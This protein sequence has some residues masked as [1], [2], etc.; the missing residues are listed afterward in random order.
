M[1]LCIVMITF[2][3]SMQASCPEA[4][5]DRA[6]RVE[7]SLDA[8]SDIECFVIIRSALEQPVAVSFYYKKDRIGS[9]QDV[10][11]VPA[12]ESFSTI[13]GQKGTCFVIP[14]YRWCEKVATGGLKPAKVHL[15][16][17]L[18]GSSIVGVSVTKVGEAPPAKPMARLGQRGREVYSFEV[19]QSRLGKV[20][21]RVCASLYK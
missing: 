18:K 12:S 15:V 7:L 14:R 13:A 21:L 20:R 10:V 1:K 8:A 9:G 2:F 17:A 16:D 19:T 11:I 5:E 6:G 3:F 4:F